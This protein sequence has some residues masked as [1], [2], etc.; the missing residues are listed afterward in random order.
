MSMIGTRLGRAYDSA[1][2]QEF[3]N[4]KG[5]MQMNMRTMIRGVMSIVVV[6]VV[7]TASAGLPVTNG[8]LYDLDARQKTT[9]MTIDGDGYLTE[10]RSSEWDPSRAAELSSVAFTQVTSVP[11]STNTYTAPHFNAD[12]FDGRGSV[13]FGYSLDETANESTPLHCNKT[14]QHRT[15]FIVAKNEKRP[16]GGWVVFWG[17][18]LNYVFGFYNDASHFTV[19]ANCRGGGTI[20]ANGEE[21]ISATKTQNWDYQQNAMYVFASEVDQDMASGSANCVMALGSHSLN[22]VGHSPYNRHL[23]GDVAEFLAYDR[24]LTD[25]ERTAVVDYLIGKWSFASDAPVTDGLV[26]HL[27][28]NDE[29]T[30]RLDADN[31]VMK[32]HSKTPNAFSLVYYGQDEKDFGGSVGVKPTL[33]PYWQADGG[34]LGKPAV[35]IGTALDGTTDV[36]SV[37]YASNGQQIK[38]RTCFF[39]TRTC[40]NGHRMSSAALALWA[41]K[42][43]PYNTIEMTSS[44]NPQWSNTSQLFKDGYAWLDGELAYDHTT[45]TASFGTK[46]TPCLLVTEAAAD[47]TF[48]PMLGGSYIQYNRYWRGPVSEILVYDRV[49]T[50]RERKIVTA[51]LQDKWMG[52]VKAVLWRGAEGA[53]WDVA[54]NWVPACVPGATD[55]VDLMGGTATVTSNVTVR[56]VDNGTL[57]VDTDETV[58]AETAIGPDVRLVKKGVGALALS[59]GQTYGGT[60]TLEAGT[61]AATNVVAVDSMPGVSLHL[62]ASRSD[63]LTLDEMTKDVGAWRSTV[64]DITFSPPA[65]LPPEKAVC[66]YT[67]WFDPGSG[68]PGVRFGVTHDNVHTGSYLRTTATIPNRTLLIVSRQ[69]NKYCAA[70]LGMF[71]STGYRITRSNS[72]QNAWAVAGASFV[73]VSGKEGQVFPSFEE[74]HLLV[75][76]RTADAAFQ[77]SLGVAWAYDNTS[78]IPNWIYVYNQATIHEVIAFDRVLTANELDMLQSSLMAKWNIQPE[79]VLSVRDTLSPNTQYVVKG[80][81]TLD[82]GGFEQTVTNIV[83]DANGQAV[84][85][86]LTVKGALDVTDATIAFTNVVKATEGEVIRATSLSGSDF[87][88]VDGVDKDHGLKIRSTSVWL[89][90][91]R[92]LTLILR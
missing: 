65:V 11:N 92:G 88:A 90:L 69:E 27:D 6:C 4:K 31:K 33:A 54:A 32:W 50:E 43:S 74:P 73:K 53:R 7:Q 2:V 52:G 44:L 84:P 16:V 66:D 79:A 63:T 81:A 42:E 67:P 48:E 61:I 91:V 34:Y 36:G 80:E 3:W 85:P 37:L 77:M 58:L 76:E 59:S 40:A 35:M 8:L 87:R 5:E 89:K 14:F 55:M 17:A 9:A 82:F 18:E 23:I 72:A 71:T 19:N 49:L 78:T 41:Q 75:V 38:H 20:W 10:W 13:K 29:N 70:V 83:V 30:L 51:Y 46:D 12:G 28:A 24:V 45:L 56:T 64:G 26:C 57:V 21:V 68:R 60:T 62:D 47:K 25:E 86:R 15:V 22:Y 1:L 39:V